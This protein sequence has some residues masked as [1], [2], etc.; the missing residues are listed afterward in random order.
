[1]ITS[2][3]GY[4]YIFILS[5]L[6]TLLASINCQAITRKQ[7]E[8]NKLLTLAT[9]KD[10][11]Q[12]LC[13]NLSVPMDYNNPRLGKIELP[14][15]VHLATKKNPL[16][17]LIFNFGGP[18]ADNANILP[19]MI[20]NRLTTPM[21][22]Y[23]NIVVINPRGTKPNLIQCNAKNTI[24]FEETNDAMK[25]IFSQGNENDAG[26]IYELAKQKQ[27]LCQYDKLYQ[28][29]STSNSVQDIEA[30][31][32]SLNAE[33]LNLYMASY[34]TRLGL[35]YLV[36]YPQHVQRIILD[37]NIAPS[38]KF[39]SLIN[40]RAYGSITTF[41][42]FF[43]YCFNAGSK[44]ALNH[45]IKDEPIK[46]QAS[47]INKFNQFLVKT[48]QGNGI[49]TGARYSHRPI[50]GG[51]IE[52]LI[53]SEMQP[54]NWKNISQAIYTAKK[55]NN[56]DELMKI[57]IANT[58]YDPKNDSYNTDNNATRPSVIC[59]DYVVPNFNKKTTW[60][61]FIRQINYE[62]SKIGTISTLWL[63]PICIKWPATS[64][65]LL[66]QPKKFQSTTLPRVLLIGN[67]K[68]P[69]TP[70]EN[71]LSVREYLKR[72]NIHTTI[73]KWNGLSHTALMTDS[74]VSVCTFNNVDKF[75]LDK[76]LPNFIECND[77]K[78]PFTRENS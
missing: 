39:I 58:G 75:L 67:A 23:F 17:Y 31:R 48:K 52:N 37:G 14:I 20:K 27:E 9:C 53:F 73:L 64:T 72:F 21:I 69:M 61:N 16:G 51:M 45:L 6:L 62:Y 19:S 66:P 30:L 44:C 25:R 15:R 26:T 8:A 24:Q 78:N 28:Y 35:A 38:N 76:S 34:G 3:L 40:G 56:G 5:L 60:L 18:W 11:Q 63:S 55:N 77:W 13:G 41:N 49:P 70:F 74:P 4:K 43:Q 54:S 57:Y 1:M 33:K 10:N 71:A 50:T 42:A 65:P 47:L 22:E 29:A 2:S 12:F 7:F 59:E 68:D 46:L 32:K 36:K